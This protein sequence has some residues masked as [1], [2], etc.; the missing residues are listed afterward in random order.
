MSW[1]EAGS[2]HR[3]QRLAQRVRRR[4]WL[5]HALA[6]LL[7]HGDNA[8]RDQQARDRLLRRIWRIGP[9]PPTAASAAHR[10]PPDVMPWNSGSGPGGSN[11]WGTPG[12]SRADRARAAAITASAAAAAP[13]AAAVAAVAR[14]G[15]PGGRGQM[16]DL[17]QIIARH[18]GL[19]PLGCCP[20]RR[21]RRR[22]AVRA[23][24]ARRSSCVWL[25]SGFYRVQP[26]EQG[27]VLRFGAFNRTD[28]AGP[29][30]HVPWPVESVLPPDG[31][32]HQPHRDRLSLGTGARNRARTAASATCPR[33]A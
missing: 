20:R 24:G 17:D 13:G 32:A 28:A 29:H 3:A 4:G 11:P 8:A 1:P 27:V 9:D 15:F 2:L 31:D 14:G 10:R 7:L 22:A 12:G 5:G 18:P 33:K 19:H 21:L 16:P 25:A 23:A 30:Y 26:D 6:N